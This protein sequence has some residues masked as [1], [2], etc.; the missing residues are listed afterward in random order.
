ML[1]YEPS[2]KQAE[3]AAK[4]HQAH[5]AKTLESLPKPPDATNVTVAS[6]DNKVLGYHGPALRYT[7]LPDAHRSWPVIDSYFTFLVCMN[8]PFASPD[9]LTSEFARFGD[10][11]MVMSFVSWPLPSL[12]CIHAEMAFCVIGYALDGR[13]DSIAGSSAAN[14]TE[15]W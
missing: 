9:W 7:A 2:R 5:A 13:F 3:L 12:V 1:P 6:K 4:E 10:G 15:C 8:I 11:A 14:T